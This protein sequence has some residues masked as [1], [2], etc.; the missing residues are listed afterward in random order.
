V[1]YERV[2]EAIAEWVRGRVQAA[3]AEGVVVGLSGGLDSSVV[4]A[5]C[6]RAVGRRV[7]GVLMPCES[8]AREM[9]DAA[10]LASRLG[11]S[12][13][14]V[15]LDSPYK[16][17]LAQL[18]PGS[19]KA[20][21]NLKAR[22]RMATLYYF[23]NSLNYLVA[24]TGNRTELTVGYF[25]KYGDGGVDLLPIGGLLKTQ[26][27]RLALALGIPRSIIERPP[28]AG[29]W[30]GQTDEAE[31]GLSYETLDAVIEALE[32]GR[33][34]PA[35]AEVVAKVERMMAAARHKRDLPPVCESWKAEARP[36]GPDRAPGGQ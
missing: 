25:T 6:V 33:Q 35:P 29:L 12:S 1:D 13:R 24:G 28:T 16:A 18:P 22:L 4:L 36:A 15:S 27:R 20:R 30:P 5:L 34:P 32:E 14:T 8:D 19:L 2:A 23:A 31:M 11:A 26:V 3:G 9:D 10:G 17:L 21:G 7:L